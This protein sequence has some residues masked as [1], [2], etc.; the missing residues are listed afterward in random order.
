MRDYRSTPAMIS[1]EVAATETRGL[2]RPI[3]VATYARYSTN[4][5]DARSI[6]DQLRRCH[7][8]AGKNGL[9]VVADFSDAASSGSHL[10][11]DDLQRLLGMIKRGDLYIRH[12][13]VDDLSRLSRDL[14][15]AWR[16]LYSEFAS[17]DV[18]VIDCTTGMASDG[19]GARVTFGALALANDTFLQLVRTETHRGLEGRALAGF[20]TGGKTFGYSSIAEPHPSDVEHPRRLPIV[21]ENEAAVVRRVFEMY[22]G[23]ET[24]KRIAFALNEEG[25]PAPHDGGSKGRKGNKTC[26]GWGHTT[27]R[28]MLGNGR[29]IGRWAWNQRKW[30]RVPGKATRR[31]IERPE[32]EHVVIDLPTLRIVPPELWDR[33][34]ER[35]GTRKPGK[36]R[37]MG[38]GK[39]GASLLTGLLRCGVCGGSIVI[40]SR[41]HKNGASYANF[42]C[43][44]NRSRGKSICANSRTAS[45]RKVIEKVIQA[46]RAQLTTPGL[47]ERFQASFRKQFAEL[48]GGGAR[49]VTKALE[50]DLQDAE[51]R[52]R[53]VT[54]GLAKIGFSDALAAQLKAEE[55]RLSDAKAALARATQ[56]R[57]SV[58]PHP[59]LIEKYLRN[60]LG[61]LETDKDAARALLKRHMP[62]LVLTPEGPTFRIKGGFDLSIC[63]QEAAE[64]PGGASASPESML[65]RVAGA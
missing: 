59:S 1:N 57:A 22:A 49:K 24:F 58:L 46:L 45:E 17:I 18:S 42:G 54:V 12:V 38:A 53:N 14:G 27:I 4:R 23:G 30:V 37:A 39:M 13:L 44:V 65:G 29:Y 26:H 52:V 25:I 34:Q 50:R 9:R 48:N 64:A 55:A 2:H 11:R 32:A 36:G 16:L 60:L 10:D 62:P 51:S 15:D 43:T 40:V 31:A 20:H 3:P 47:V 6:D 41:R 8:H 21:E 61:L 7:A 5:Q 19:A 35:L 56:T 33:V 28:A 63:L